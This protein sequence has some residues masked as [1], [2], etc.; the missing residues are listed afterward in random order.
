MVRRRQSLVLLALLA[1]ACKAGG[2]KVP[3]GAPLPANLLRPYEGELRILRHQ[4]DQKSVKAKVQERLGGDCDV[5]VRIGSA[6]FEKRTARFSL[7]TI[8][9]PSVNGQ[10]PRCKRLQPR[11]QL[12]ITGFPADPAAA[13]VLAQ[14]EERLQTP[15]TYLRAKGG[16]FGLPPGKAPDEVASELLDANREERA[17]ARVTTAWPKVLLSVNPV[18]R[19]P[20]KRVRQQGVVEFEALVGTDGRLYRPLLKASVG[21]ANE[22]TVMSAFSFWRFAPARRGDALVGARVPLRLVLH[23]Y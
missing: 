14:V 10:E 5:A 4:G 9:L 13:D 17:L 23:I 21:D 8:G 20:S 3:P 7:E 11:I 18:N 22:A 15:E 1:A 19:A 12:A 2:P 6:G 16:Q